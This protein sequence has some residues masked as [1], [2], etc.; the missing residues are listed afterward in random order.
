MISGIWANIDLGDIVNLVDVLPDVTDNICDDN[1]D[2]DAEHD[3][4][5]EL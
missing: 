4:D 3:I 1:S 5:D 2:V